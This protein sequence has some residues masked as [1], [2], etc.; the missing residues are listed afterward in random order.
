M[1]PQPR[2]WNAESYQRVSA[3]LEAMGREVL[4]RLELRG[5][6]RVL[7]AGCGTGRVTAALLERLPRGEVVAVDGSP[8]MVAEARERLGPRADVRVADLTELELEAPVDAILS[9]AT[10]HWIADHDRL[11]ERM[12]AVLKPGGRLVAQCG[13]EGNVATVQAA[14]DRVAEPALTGWGGPWN[15][16]SPAATAARLERLGFTEVRTWPQVVRVEPDD[17]PEYLTTVI[18][19]SHLERVPAERRDAF[20]AAVLAEMP[21]PAIEYVRLNLS[22]RRAE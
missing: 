6:E 13:G 18:L 3:P 17:P 4:D 21:E 12:H 10:F 11:F 9:T 20:V 15:F 5:D 22:G 14:I 2:D 8:A 1:N 7:D 16:A 19:G